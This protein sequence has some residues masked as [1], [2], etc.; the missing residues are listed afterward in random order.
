MQVNCPECSATL[1]GP[2][3]EE[4]VCPACM[5]PFLVPAEDAAV[6]R[7]FD[8]QLADGRVLHNVGRYALREG[9]YAGRIDREAR[10]RHD[11]GK[12]E[13]I[14][15]YR[16]F[17]AVFRVLGEELGSLPGTRKLADTGAPGERAR[18]PLSELPGNLFADGPAAPRAAVGGA[19]GAS[20]GPA[21]E[22]PRNL[23]DDPPAPH[24]AQ[25]AP[26][27]P[28]ADAPGAEPTKPTLTMPTLGAPASVV[29]EPTV[30]DR[31]VS[32]RTV[33]SQEATVQLDARAGATSPRPQPATPSRTQPPG[34]GARVGDPPRAPS[35]A[36]GSPAR[37]SASS[38]GVAPRRPAPTARVPIVLPKAP[39]RSGTSPVV[40]GLGVLAV[41]LGAL[42]LFGGAGVTP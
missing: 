3:G 28:A 26:A 38:S 23:F 27:A 8:V 37:P 14:G 42:Y 29:A 11:G 20:R 7:A 22:S 18:G 6:V 2:P 33:P 30:P 25:S 16:E 17:A 34:A 39:E 32:E 36:D 1:D 24:A 19:A 40:L 10:V 35:A 9:I 4:M 12:W 13:K 5:T 41:V 31:T 21:S 15:G